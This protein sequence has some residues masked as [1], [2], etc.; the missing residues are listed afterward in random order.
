M[1]KQE[2]DM[3]WRK[4]KEPDGCPNCGSPIIEIIND[5]NLKAWAACEDCGA[6][7]KLEFAEPYIRQR[8][9]QNWGTDNRS[10]ARSNEHQ[11]LLHDCCF[12]IACSVEDFP[13]GSNYVDERL[14]FRGQNL[15]FGY[16]LSG[17]PVAGEDN[18]RKALGKAQC[19]VFS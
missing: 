1:R 9:S 7:T 17:K 10:T 6:E 3:K 19:N 11:E 4:I 14:V 16:R 12:A 2:A 13:E 5:S 8:H 15:E 18:G